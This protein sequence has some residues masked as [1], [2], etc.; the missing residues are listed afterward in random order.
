MIFVRRAQAFL[1]GFIAPLKLPP[2]RWQE[3][4]QRS[5]MRLVAPYKGGF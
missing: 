1:A 4:S 3:L 2:S 5:A